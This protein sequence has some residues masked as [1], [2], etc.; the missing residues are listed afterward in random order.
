[1]STFLDL[2]NKALRRL[3]E[4]PL[5]ASTFPNA[6]GF[7]AV[8]KEAVNNAIREI[9]RES[10]EWPFNIKVGSQVLVPGQTLYDYPADAKIIDFDTFKIEYVRETVTHHGVLE[11][12]DYDRYVRSHYVMDQDLI[13]SGS[14]TVPSRVFKHGAQFGVACVPS[15]AD[16]LDFTYWGWSDE[17]VAYT[18]TTDIPDRY[19]DVIMFGVLRECY[20]FRTMN[21]QSAKYDAMFTDGIKGMRSQLLNDF[22]AV[23]DTRLG[24]Y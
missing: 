5:T 3:N 7:H 21:Q 11:H 9:N 1:M 12:I 17:L 8:T 2:T 4:V 16:T 15:N 10:H 13:A 6:V 23:T 18:D 19:D 24:I 22:V 14:T 20:D